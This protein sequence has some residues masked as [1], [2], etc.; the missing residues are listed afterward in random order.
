MDNSIATILRFIECINAHD[1]D[2]LCDLMT[3]DHAFYDSQGNIERS[4]DHMRNSWIGY[5]AW[6]PDYTI[7]VDEAI[8]DADTVVVLGRAQGTYCVDG[9][10]P[11][12][13]RW[14]IPAAWRAKVR[15]GLVSEW[16]IYADNEPV[17]RIMSSA[18]NKDE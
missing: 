18:S 6:F 1:V 14:Q 5:L 8:A 17:L 10:L 11:E 4:R 15:N 16:Q 9:Q 7:T 3:D 12:A 2:A 13:N